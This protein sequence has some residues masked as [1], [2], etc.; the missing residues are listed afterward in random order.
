MCNEHES[1]CT[2]TS[3]WRN[4]QSLQQAVNFNLVDRVAALL[5]TG[6]GLEECADNAYHLLAAAVSRGHLE[7]VRLLL[8]TGL[9]DVNAHRDDEAGSTPLV[10]A[11]AR[12]HVA[13]A[14]LLLDH[15]AVLDTSW[16]DWQGEPH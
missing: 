3:W 9:C 14:E 15:G 12:G 11:C 7:V 1:L 10:I 6:A 8:E 13:V 4:G 5:C 2:M 16:H